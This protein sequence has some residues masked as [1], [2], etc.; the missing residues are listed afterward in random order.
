MKDIKDKPDFDI[1]KDHWIGWLRKRMD[2]TP[3][4]QGL[5]T[6]ALR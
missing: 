6:F 4:Q 2:M 1:E 5:I 3:F